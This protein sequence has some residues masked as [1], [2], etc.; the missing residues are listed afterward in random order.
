MNEADFDRWAERNWGAI[1]DAAKCL[2]EPIEDGAI[3][4][5]IFSRRH[6]RYYSPRACKEST[7]VYL[8]ALWL[9]KDI[10][11]RSHA[12]K[13]NRGVPEILFS[14]LGSGEPRRMV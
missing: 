6:V 5:Y 10:W 8:M 7:W 11:K 9:R 12:L 1:V 13:R 2:S 4:L 14:E 3:D